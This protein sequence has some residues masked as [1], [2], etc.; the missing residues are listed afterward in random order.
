MPFGTTPIAPEAS[1]H[2]LFIC[3]SWNCSLG[4]QL[5]LILPTW[6]MRGFVSLETLLSLRPPPYT[7]SSGLACVGG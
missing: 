5:V 1:Y 3:G 2:V 6:D 7:N 4:M